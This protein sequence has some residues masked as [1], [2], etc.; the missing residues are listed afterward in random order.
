MEFARND[1]WFAGRVPKALDHQPLDRI[2]EQ[3]AGFPAAAIANWLQQGE[4][5]VNQQ[6]A[7]PGQLVRAGELIGI[8]LFPVEDYGYEPTYQALDVCY[9]DDHLLVINKPAGQ[10]VH[11]NEPG[12][13][14]TLLNAL[15]MHYQMQGL[16]TRVRLLHR[17]DQDTS[18][19]I[20]FPKH[21]LAQQVLD[22]LLQR[23]AIT[24][25]YWAVVS[26]QVAGKQG[27]VDAPIGRDRNH[28]TRRR[29]SPTG[30]QAVTTW[31]VVERLAGATLLEAN[32]QTGRTHQIRVH[33]AHLKHP[34]LGDELYGGATNRFPRQALHARLLRFPHPFT[35][36][37]LEIAAPLPA[38]YQELLTQLHSSFV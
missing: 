11:P 31:R 32:L 29:V 1:D 28:P 20:L 33:L 23:R 36:E 30:Q 27:V 2:L 21:A 38:D 12:E 10:K 26:G 9:E 34:L 16:Q 8:R 35:G 6:R 3:T 24:R 19:A 4:V 22:Q 13:T 17:L 18:G 37:L 7:T 5:H 15:A 14:D 25:L